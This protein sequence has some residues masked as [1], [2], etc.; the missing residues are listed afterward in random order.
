MET[1]SMPTSD[2]T[3][4]HFTRMMA[5]KQREFSSKMR[6]IDIYDNDV[7]NEALAALFRGGMDHL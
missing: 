6:Y 4:L 2:L 1:L 5:L 7:R 3:D